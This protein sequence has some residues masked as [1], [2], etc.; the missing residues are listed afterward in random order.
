[1]QNRTR[2]GD[3]RSSRTKSLSRP[4][5][6][7]Q[8]PSARTGAP[9]QKSPCGLHARTIR[10]RRRR[11]RPCRPH[12]PR[13]HRRT[14][15]WHARCPR[16]TCTLPAARHVSRFS[17]HKRT[18]CRP[19]R[20][21]R[22]AQNHTVV[23]PPT[24]HTSASRSSCRVADR[25]RQLLWV[26]TRAGVRRSHARRSNAVREAESKSQVRGRRSQSDIRYLG[27]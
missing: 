11:R 9:S 7:P 24:G 20:C 12:R 25:I 27:Q 10:F 4:S 26:L 2:S 14:R 19:S 13:L 3:C 22:A 6:A 5:L 23:I 1:M 8:R 21:A 16:A 17:F 18:P 15:L